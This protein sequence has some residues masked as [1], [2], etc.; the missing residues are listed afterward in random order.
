MSVIQQQQHQQHNKC[1]ISV[2]KTDS[3]NSG[4]VSLNIRH[5]ILSIYLITFQLRL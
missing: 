5:E 4:E 2:I 3:T 1:I